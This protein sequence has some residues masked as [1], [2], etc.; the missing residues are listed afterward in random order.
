MIILKIYGTLVV[1]VKNNENLDNI[2]I[3]SPLKKNCKI[4][5]GGE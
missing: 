4:T 1:L 2:M 3:F 5:H